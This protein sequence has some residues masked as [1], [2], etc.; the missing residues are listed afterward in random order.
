MSKTKSCC[1]TGCKNRNVGSESGVIFYKFPEEKN[2]RKRWIDACVKNDAIKEKN[3]AP[4]SDTVICNV[5]FVTGK[6]LITSMI[7]INSAINLINK[8]SKTFINVE[9]EK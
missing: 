3:W 7:N 4:I 6:I 9:W 1:V 2:L 5:H 8:H